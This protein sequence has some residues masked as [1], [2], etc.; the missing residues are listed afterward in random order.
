MYY[1]IYG[2]PSQFLS[3]D[4]SLAEITIQPTKIFKGEREMKTE[5]EFIILI[6]VKSIFVPSI[7][8]QTPVLKSVTASQKPMLIPITK[9]MTLK[10][11]PLESYDCGGGIYR[12][13]IQYQNDIYSVS[14]NYPLIGECDFHIRLIKECL[15]V[16]RVDETY[17]DRFN[18]PEEE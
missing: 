10:G 1:T 6:P 4:K 14:R 3:L 2:K 8:A 18:F 7:I 5:G 13:I 9:S 16:G 12:T 11:T 15:S 17:L